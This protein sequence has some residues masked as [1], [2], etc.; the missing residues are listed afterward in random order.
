MDIT[1]NEVA[2]LTSW[3]RH[4]HQNP[5]IAFAE[6][7][8]ASFI[9]E[10]LKSFG[11]EVHVGIGGTGVVG[12]IHG[13]VQNPIKAIGLRADIDALP[14]IEQTNLPHASQRDG[15]MHAC[16]HDGHTVMLLGA[17]RRLSESRNFVGIVYCIFQPAEEG[18]NAGARAMIE[19]GLFERFPMESVWGL[20]NWPG[21]PVGTAV[22]HSG[23]AMA[24]NDIFTLTISGVGGHAAIPHQTCDPIVAIGLCIV[25]LQNLVARQADPF[26]PIVLSLTKL[27]AGSA[28]NIIPSTGSISGTLRCM[29]TKTRMRFLDKIANTAKHAVGTVGCTVE[30]E[31]HGGY[32]PTINDPN[33]AACANEVAAQIFGNEAIAWDTAPSMVAEDFAFMLQKKPGAYIWLGAGAESKKLHSPFFDFNDELLPLGINYWVQLTETQL[34]SE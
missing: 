6:H 30:M 20:H 1:K 4:L 15:C 32:P 19:D 31:I 22:A 11:V 24:G 34:A 16:G 17:A 9:A 5:E 27:A 26:E 29:C 23:P 8:T 18:S 25:S 28:F 7:G 3:R 33:K 14:M 2:E 10:K 12:V 21:L 13:A